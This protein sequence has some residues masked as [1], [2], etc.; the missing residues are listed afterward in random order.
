VKNR[1]FV[2]IKPSAN[3]RSI[4]AFVGD[5]LA[6]KHFKIT[7]RGNFS[8]G[9]ED[10][11]DIQHINSGRKATVL[12]P[13]E[14][15]IPIEGL[16]AFQEC[17]GL[18]W[19][20]SLE[21][22]L[23]RNALE[24]LDI[25]EVSPAK[26]LEEW[27][28]CFE[29]GTMIKL[30]RHTYCALIDMPDRPA[31]FCINGFHP[32]LRQEYL[33]P[34]ASIHYYCVEWDE[35]LSTWDAFRH[36][37]IGDG[38]PSK[39]GPNT[40]R[41]VIHA[42]WAELGLQAPL[43]L[44]HNAIHASSSSFEAFS[45]H[46]N[47]L[48]IS[49]N[50]D[51]LGC[52]LYQLGLTPQTLKDWLANT[53]I[54]GKH[55]FDYFENKGS[56]E[57]I[58]VVRDIISQGEGIQSDF[59]RLRNG[60]QSEVSEKR[61]NAC[62]VF[63]KPHANT[64]EVRALTQDYLRSQG[65]IISEEKSINAQAIDKDLLV[66][67]QY[68]S[69]AR[70]A[71]F[72][73]PKDYQF[74]PKSYIRFQKKFGT[75]WSDEIANN[76]ICNAHEIVL[77]LEIT[78]SQL[79]KAWTRC[80]QDG[81]YIKLEREFYCGYIDS[82]QGKP[83]LF[84]I[85]GFY[86][87]MRAQYLS[88]SAS[89]HCYTV[90]WE[91]DVMSWKTFSRDVIGSTDP[92]EAKECSLRSQV[93]RLWMEL[94]LKAPLDIQNNAIHASSSAFEAM[95]ER[96]IWFK[97][98]LKGDPYF[99]KRLV[100][101]GVNSKILREWSMNCIV[102]EIRLFDHMQHLG[103]DD[104]IEKALALLCSPATS[105]SLQLVPTKNMNPIVNTP[106]L[107]TIQGRAAAQSGSK[108]LNRRLFERAMAQDYKEFASDESHGFTV[109]HHPETRSGQAMHS[110]HMQRNGENGFQHVH[111]TQQN[112]SYKKTT[113]SDAV[114][115]LWNTKAR[116]RYI[117]DSASIHDS[118]CETSDMD[119]PATSHFSREGPTLNLISNAPG[120]TSGTANLYEI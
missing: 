117:P 56:D 41:G 9:M 96:S 65:F 83:P 53:P 43:D 7:A 46:L 12:R 105:S 84:C 91:D 75:S 15:N 8:G 112:V 94:D 23:I 111:V 92:E 89:I 44:F 71:L 66:D 25:L 61:R 35:S 82:I 64:P 76:T 38:D 77:R 60:N 116:D 20:A 13:Y 34:D 18:S 40:L 62:L 70:M 49:I 45:E 29:A 86:M 106:H 52:Y 14:L 80:M 24:A 58:E 109:D 6:A 50:N 2:Y 97:Q 114:K 69:I 51:P 27:M 115:N 78:H 63:I 95:V 26:L 3:R 4:Q 88:P 113:Y 31:I 102:N 36:D 87:A 110:H 107:P 93:N 30:A 48:K 28:K 17:Y 72:L 81:S 79:N 118:E 119:H 67:K 54:R 74:S 120:P 1:A 21:E 33:A 98:S 5:W 37:V 57:C 19:A 47:W 39:A 85:N 22:G 101:A 55:A 42:E 103:A 16:A 68:A 59:L 11:F 32:A 10:E 73:S 108:S 100:A 99:G 90:E 104:C